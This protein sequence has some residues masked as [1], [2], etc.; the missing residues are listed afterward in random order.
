[1]DWKVDPTIVNRVRATVYDDFYESGGYGMYPTTLFGFVLVL[2]ACLYLFR[3]QARFVPVVV[4]AGC[5]T[6]ASGINGMATGLMHVFRYVQYVD[7]ADA[8]KVAALGCAEA[9]TNVVL[10]A[11]LVVIG[12][13]VMLAGFVR[14]ALRH[15]G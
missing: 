11:V 14:R 8:V 15:E 2:A 3:P 10:A 5:L 9:I 7:A 1:M 6:V 4:T 13:L 12:G